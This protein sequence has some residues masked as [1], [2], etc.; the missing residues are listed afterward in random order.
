MF[1]LASLAIN[2]RFEPDMHELVRRDSEFIHDQAVKPAL[3]LLQDP[4]FSGAEEEFQSAYERFRKGDN[5]GAIADTLKAFESTMKAICDARGWTYHSGA[6]ASALIAIMFD[7]RLVPAYLANHFGGLR[8]A[9]EAGVPTV[10]NKTSG[11]GQGAVPQEVPDHL[12]A[13]ALH[14]AASNIVFLVQ[15]HRA[16]G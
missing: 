7:K 3:A 4:A 13:F 11:H 6:T 5:K 14:L 9:L 12:V 16:L 1:I 15:A 10:R 2:Y 8:S